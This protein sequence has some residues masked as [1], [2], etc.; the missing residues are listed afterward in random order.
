M[1]KSVSATYT[2]E[3][4]LYC[5]FFVFFL[6]EQKNFKYVVNDEDLYEAGM[7]F[8]GFN[9]R[10][11]LKSKAQQTMIFY[12]LKALTNNVLNVHIDVTMQYKVTI[13]LCRKDFFFNAFFFE[14]KYLSELVP[15]FNVYTLLFSGFS[16]SFRFFEKKYFFVIFGLY[17]PK[18]HFWVEHV[19]SIL[20]I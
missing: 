3:F 18:W 16:W 11:N 2:F 20:K 8:I 17:K 13:V 14:L 9:K 6:W 4:C 10:I 15:N 19:F 7:Y 12:Q 5:I 1:S